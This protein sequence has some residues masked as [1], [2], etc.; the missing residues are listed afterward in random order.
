MS[1]LVAEAKTEFDSLGRGVHQCSVRRLK[2]VQERNL[3]YFAGGDF[4]HGGAEENENTVDKM[5][6][7]SSLF[8]LLLL[9]SL[10]NATGSAHV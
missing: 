4:G 8:F 10:P 3:G 9:F 6:A 5:D 1:G 7:G 2:V